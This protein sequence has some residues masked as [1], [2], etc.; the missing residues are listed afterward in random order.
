MTIRVIRTESHCIFVRISKK[1]LIDTFDNIN[2]KGQTIHR[3]PPNRA[4]TECQ[5]VSSTGKAKCFV[6]LPADFDERTF[7]I[8]D[9]SCIDCHRRG[10]PNGCSFLEWEGDTMATERQDRTQDDTL[11]LTSAYQQDPRRRR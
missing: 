7:E 4:C 5:G 8:P 2:T 9:R 10:N 6:V 11:Q 3:L 1:A